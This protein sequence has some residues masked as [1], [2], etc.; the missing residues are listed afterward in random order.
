MTRHASALRDPLISWFDLDRIF[1]IAQRER[2]RVKEPVI[3]LGDPFADRM[4]RQ[5]AVIADGNVMMAA[6]LPRIHVP[7]HRMAVHACLRIVAHVAGTLAVAKSERPQ[8]SEHANNQS[9]S[10]HSLAKTRLRQANFFTRIDTVHSSV[11]FAG[12]TCRFRF[13]CV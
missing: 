11:I 9:Q 3:R 8:A 1:V 2:E 4:M 5:V 13:R 10:K 7:L 12:V 6:L